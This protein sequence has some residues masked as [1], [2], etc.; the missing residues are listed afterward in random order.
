MKAPRRHWAGLLLLTVILA[1]TLHRGDD[2]GVVLSYVGPGAGFAFGSPQSIIAVGSQLL[3]SNAPY[4]FASMGFGP[5]F[6]SF[7]TGTS[8]T[9]QLTTSRKVPVGFT[10]WPD[11]NI[12]VVNNGI[13]DFSTGTGVASTAGSI[14]VINPTS[15]TIVRTIDLGLTLPGPTVAI[16]SD[17]LNAFTGSGEG[18]DLLKINVAS[19]AVTAKQFSTEASFVSDVLVD[20]NVVY[21]LSFLE[22]RIYA[23]DANT[24]EPVFLNL[25]PRV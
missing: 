14:D 18:A 12:A 15:H 22:D 13:A 6:I 10:P 21:V 24:L 19:G 1:A 9:A 25:E 2:P 3:V 7:V 4:D 8:I 5:G 11:G 16:S 20:G 23:V 17:G